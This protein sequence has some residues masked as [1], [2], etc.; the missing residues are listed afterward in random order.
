MK[1]GPADVLP[2]LLVE[3]TWGVEPQTYALRVGKFIR[4]EYATWAYSVSGGASVGLDCT[5]RREFMDRSVDRRSCAEFSL[6]RWR[7][8][9]TSSAST[10]ARA[11]SQ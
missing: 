6:R 8:D 2:G 9:P 7:V 11:Q 5:D 1:E 4:Q 3:P 10:V